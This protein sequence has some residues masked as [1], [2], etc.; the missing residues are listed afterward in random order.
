MLHGMRIIKYFSWEDHFT[1][2]IEAIRSKELVAILHLWATRLVYRMI[3]GASGIFIAFATLASYSLFFGKTLDAATAFTALNLLMI[4]SDFLSKVPMRFM[5]VFNAKASLDRIAKYLAEPEIERFGPANANADVDSNASRV[6]FENASFVYHGS[7]SLDDAFTLRN[8]N[9]TFEPNK[10]HLVTGPTGCGKTSLFMALLGEMHAVTGRYWLPT[11]K[12]HVVLNAE[13]GL[14]Q[15]V[16]FAAQ[17]P[18]ILNATIRDNILFGLPY[19]PARYS[20]VIRGC[21]LIPDLA[22]LEGGDLTEIGEKGINLSGGQKARI[23]LARACYS[24]ASIVLLDHP[25]A[26]V[27]APTARFLLKRVLLDL[28]KDRTIIIASH[29]LSLIGP[30]ADQIVYIR[31]GEIVCSKDPLAFNALQLYP[32]LDLSQKTIDEDESGLEEEFSPTTDGQGTTLVQNEAKATGALDWSV[33]SFYFKACGGVVFLVSFFG[34]FAL[35]SGTKVANSWWLK[36]WTDHNAQLPK[37]AQM[38]SFL[39]FASSVSGTLATDDTL[40]YVQ[41]YALLGFLVIVASNLQSVTYIAG[42]YYASLKIHADLL[43]HILRAPLRFFETTPSGRVMNRFSKDIESIDTSVMDAT[44][45]FMLSSMQAFTVVAVIGTIAPYFLLVF[46]LV[47]SAYIYIAGIYLKTSRELKRYESINRSPIY[48]QF[49]ETLNGIC[50][51]RAYGQEP[52]FTMQNQAM[53]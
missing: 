44:Q 42:S 32:A 9:H 46:P 51:I 17:T 33:Y 13:L 45:F 20:R 1:R 31:S 37:E 3:G 12:K 18:W 26:A 2:K 19:D 47:A 50:T 49:S 7:E 28:L 53:M 43:R 23:S 36:V 52:R 38:L 40:Y 29:A 41:I 25:F 24:N 14:N 10:L 34:A 8:L 16:A 30:F 48:A 5:M 39:M 4:I 6:G 27:D 21:A 15:T 11:N 22:V 35:F